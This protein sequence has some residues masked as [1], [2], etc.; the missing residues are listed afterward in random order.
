M[1]CI[2][3]VPL[4][5]VRTLTDCTLSVSKLVFVFSFHISWDPGDLG[6]LSL[7]LSLNSNSLHLSSLYIS[8]YENI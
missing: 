3:I 2:R 7:E 4:A 8:A 1:Y 5:S 6:T